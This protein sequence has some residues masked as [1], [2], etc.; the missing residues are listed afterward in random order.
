MKAWL[1]LIGIGEDGI[2]A[3]SPAAKRLI[4]GAELVVGGKRHLALAGEFAGEALAWPSPLTDALAAILAR[5][6]RPVAVLASGDPFFHGVGSTL[7]RKIDPDEII[8]LPAPSAFSLA[9]A[10]LG[11]AQ[12]D[13]AL[14]SLHG[15]ALE[16]IIP[17]LQPGARIL[18]LSWDETT[19]KKVAALLISRGMGS[20]RLVLCEAMG[21]PRERLTSTRADAFSVSPIDPLNT[22]AIEVVAEP[23]AEVVPLAAGLADGMFEH[24]GQITKRDIRAATIAA[25]APRRA[26]MLWDIGAGS[27]SIGIEW[28]LR[29]PHNRAIAIETR[30][31][32]AARIARN[33]GR[34]GVPDLVVIEGR[35]PEAL[36]G[37]PRPDAVFVGGGAS[38]D[39]V[40]DAAWE[41]LPRGGRLVANAVTL[42]TQAELMRRHETQGG[43]LVML[44][45]AV[46]EPLGAYHG[47][48]PAMPVMRL[49]AV[50]P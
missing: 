24:D 20:S 2:E 8:C 30:S 46:A 19:P 7:T 28:M 50:K 43:E 11:W 44:Q 31:D 14:L 23:G 34:L 42:E 12:Q 18:A 39:G 15:H 21:G 35:A 5:R 13:C 16:R 33:A 37:L 38:R 45:I 48:R 25:L 6:G 40:L 47:F 10:R 17:H 29:H 26:E 41:A 3:L 36:A 1:S 27:G 4:Q 9:A 22:L 32:R 49:T